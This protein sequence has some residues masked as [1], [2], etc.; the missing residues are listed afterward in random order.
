MTQ[1]AAINNLV[2]NLQALGCTCPPPTIAV[3]PSGNGTTFTNTSGTC[4]LTI[5][6]NVFPSSFTIA[7]GATFNYAAFFAAFN[8]SAPHGLFHFQIGGGIVFDTTY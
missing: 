8:G 4:T 2:S 3:D 5:T 1:A 7:P 6:V